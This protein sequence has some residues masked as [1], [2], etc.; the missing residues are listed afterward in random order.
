MIAS[1]TSKT[2]ALSSLVALGLLAGMTPAVGTETTT[3]FE[4]PAEATA[5]PTEPTAP[6]EEPAPSASPSASQNSAAP[7]GSEPEAEGELSTTASEAEESSPVP[8]GG[9]A[10]V[11]DGAYMGQG[12]ERLAAGLTPQT[13]IS[14]ARLDEILQA[15]SDGAAVSPGAETP[16]TVTPM[17]GTWRPPGIQGMDVSNYQ[18]NVDWT[19]AWAQGARFAYVKASEGTFY[20]NPNFDQQYGGSTDVGMYRGAYHFAMPT[21]TSGRDQANFFVDNGGGWTSD[22]RTLPPLLDIEYNPYDAETMPSGG[23]DTCY[24]MSPAELIS[25]IRDFSN[26]IKARTGRLPMIY[27]A[28]N[29][30]NYCIGNTSAFADHP[31]HIAAYN[32]VGA[33]PVPYGWKTYSFWQ[34]SATGPFV[35][36]SNVWNGSAAALATF[37][38]GAA[39]T[40]PTDKAVRQFN[41]GDFNGDGRSDLLNRRA[42][43][44]LWLHPGQGNGRFGTPVRIGT[45]FQI[46]NHFVATGDYDGDGRNDFLARH[47]DG[48]LW[49]Y[50]GTG[51]VNSSNPGYRPGEKIGA[52]GWSSYLS[53]T[54]GGDYD[55][56][57][58]TDLLGFRSD[59]SLWYYPGPGN[60][61]HGSGRIIG[62]G[63]NIFEDIVGAGDF[64]ADGMDD[65]LARTPDG[66]LML[67][68][69]DGQGDFLTGEQIGTG[70]HI[71]TALMG[72]TDFN[73]DRRPDV[74]GIRSDQSV[75]FYAGTGLSGEGYLPALRIATNL[76]SHE[77]VTAVGNFNSAGGNDL[78]SRT[79]DGKLWFHPGTGQGS[80]DIQVEIGRGWDIYQDLIGA[81]DYNADG[82]PDL[83]AVRPDGTLW[84]YAGTGSVSATSEG[85]RPAVKIGSGWQIYSEVTSPGDYNGDGRVDL[86]AR[87][88]DG[89]LWFYAGTGSVSASSEGYR[90]AMKIGSGW[91]IYSGLAT[92]GDFNSDAKTDLIARRHD[93]TLW[94]YAGTGSVSATSE[95]YADA[96]QIGRG[97]DGF[98]HVVGSRDLTSD[99][100]NDMVAILPDGTLYLYR[101]DGMNDEGY[102]PAT[103][104]G[105]L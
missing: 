78:V 88:P 74:L 12:I 26:T 23:G 70:W 39:P 2:F 94:F 3:T 6:V 11:G 99:G 92:P 43:G 60:G 56:N 51:V 90:P 67:Y 8:S 15:G 4:A 83:L 102:R 29:W 85:Y 20:T 87:R 65:L 95:G 25:W 96:R 69:G 21:L 24:A 81:G 22:G 18:G 45:G 44:T 1:R 49:R 7:L 55:N 10:D 100:K 89:T 98:R 42:D 31:L 40:P 5:P 30:W 66:R 77:E 46:F 36:D 79:P 38:R 59:G 32:E 27:T 37:V 71:Y 64:D 105:R 57:G 33:G 86:L 28:T 97:W 17:A 16:S 58:T 47:V 61:Q 13:E 82:R 63:W 62:S 54:S 93:G 101:G 68:R 72:G 14:P 73:G 103:A 9:I 91:H 52:S 53:L 19:K 84:F 35:G 80:F 48:S 76:R 41:P 50:S 34:Y 75:W 104:G